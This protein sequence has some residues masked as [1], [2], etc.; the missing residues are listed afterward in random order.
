MECKI[1]FSSPFLSLALQHLNLQKINFQ[2]E[3]PHIQA[4]QV[5][6][7]LLF[8]ML[9]YSLLALDPPQEKNF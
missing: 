1:F 4:M 2:K 9:R 6:L 7:T 8:S 5:T 3:I